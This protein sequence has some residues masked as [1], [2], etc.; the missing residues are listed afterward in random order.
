MREFEQVLTDS[1][2]LSVK[3]VKKGYEIWKSIVTIN[4]CTRV[5]KYC[6]HRLLKIVL[7]ILFSRQLSVVFGVLICAWLRRGVPDIV[8]VDNSLDFYIVTSIE[9]YLI[10]TANIILDFK[11]LTL[12]SKKIMITPADVLIFV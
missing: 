1:Q 10:R 7:G 2:Q 8:V 6:S 4:T 12:H 3:Q 5:C 9:I 11:I